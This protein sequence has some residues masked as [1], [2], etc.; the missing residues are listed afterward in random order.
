MA[1]RD[2]VVD[3]HALAWHLTAPE[4]LGKQARRLL[5]SVD[6]GRA[7]GHVP[8]IA[9]VELSLLHERGRLRVSSDQVVAALATRPS[10][11]V[12][13]LDIEQCMRFATLPS[14][15]DPMDRLVAA[16]ALALDAVLVSADELLDVPGLS[17]AWD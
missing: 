17:R 7:R 4:R 1:S 16:S 13:A 15:K 3:T 11:S 9:L 6:A 12:L 10:W 14:I 8:A 5:D 2:V